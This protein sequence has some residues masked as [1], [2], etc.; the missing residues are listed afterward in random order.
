MV[1]GIRL[2]NNNYLSSVECQLCATHTL[3]LSV[4]EGLKQC[5][6]IHR[7]IKSLQAFQQLRE[8]V[9]KLLEL[10]KIVTRHLCGA[11][12]PTLNLIYL[13]MESLKKKF[14]PRP[15]KNETVEIYLM[16]VYGESYKENDDD[17][18]TDDDIP[19]A[20]TRWQWQHAHQQY[21]QRMSAYTNKVEDLPPVNTSG[22]LEKVRDAIYLS[23][24]ELWAVLTDT[25]LIATFLNPQ[26]KHLKWLTNNE[27]DRVHQLVKNLYNELKTNLYIPDDNEDRSSVK[28]D[29]GGLFSD[30]ECNYT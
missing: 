4:Q 21:Q 2:L 22:L 12:Y 3:Q 14:A 8:E 7:C 6:A 10:I 16:L 17:K 29:D 20:G 28:N 18:I 25:A 30:L 24:D 19:S 11:N 9:V 15:D 13:Y 26:F 5:K 27:R 23:L 1:K